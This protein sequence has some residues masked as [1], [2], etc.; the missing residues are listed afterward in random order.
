MT[1]TIGVEPRA[2]AVRVA[3]SAVRST[4]TVPI[5][6]LL[7]ALIGGAVLI[8][9][10]G[11]D[12]F[13]VYWTALDGV[14]FGPR[15]LS[16]TAT[17]ATPLILI[18]LGYALAY[19]AR[20]FT[21]GAEGQYLMGAIASVALV[22]A[23]GVRDL[24]G[25]ALMV[26]GATAA[27]MAGALWGGLAGFLQV[28]FGASV[29]ISSLM[30]VY[31]AQ[32]FLQWAIRV[33]IRDPDSFIPAS[34]ELGAATL[35]TVPG[36][37]THLG[38]LVAIVTGPCLALLLARHRLGYRVSVLGHNADALDANEVASRRVML[39]VIVWAGGLAGLA[40][41]A[42]TAG[43]NGRL[44]DSASLGYGF[45]A[46]IVALLGRLHPIGVV[47]AGLAVAA[48]KIGFEVAARSHELP[49]SLVGVIQALVVVFVVAG[50]ALVARGRGGS[51]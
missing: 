10:E 7:A 25:P 47:L 30:L 31:V 3:T 20:L 51:R 29:V 16:D 24:P 9:A 14:L 21:I 17:A 33:G 44:G 26:I 35:P 43:V 48:L 45:T 38:F 46:I 8:L 41:F 12:P 23:A 11:E 37:D 27:V 19:R 40:G 6:A 18:G 34:R 28:R 42:E 5:V 32:A 36:L 50:D 39:A 2:G 22:T 4:L 15:G 13:A 49:S 1:L